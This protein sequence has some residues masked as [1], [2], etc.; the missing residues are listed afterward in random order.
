MPYFCYS[1]CIHLYSVKLCRGK[2]DVEE[3]S[4]QEEDYVAN[5]AKPEARVLQELLVVG[6]EEHVANGHPSH[7]SSNVRHKRD[8]KETRK[9]SYFSRGFPSNQQKTCCA[10]ALQLVPSALSLWL[11]CKGWTAS[12]TSRTSLKAASECGTALLTK[13]KKT[14]NNCKMRGGKQVID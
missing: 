4:E 1:K 7:P 13:T 10:T 12:K 8:L 14:G 9:E 3:H 6:A 2:E 11:V 5:Y